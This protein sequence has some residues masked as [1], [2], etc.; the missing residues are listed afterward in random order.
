MV[1]GISGRLGRRLARKL[2]RRYKVIGVD[3]RPFPRKPKDIRHVRIDIRRRA[4]E[5]VFR[6]EDILAVIHL[7]ILHD[8]REDSREHHSINVQGTTQILEYCQRYSISKAIL[9]S[10][11]D[12]YGPRPENPQFLREEA[13]LMA[14]SGFPEVAHLIAVDL[15]FQSFFWKAPEVETVILRPVH[16]GGRVDN[17]MSRFLRMSLVP[18][19]AGFD[20]MIQLIHED[21]VI[22]GLLAALE[23]GVRGVFNLAG[24]CCVPLSRILQALGAK[25][26]PVPYSL[27]CW[28]LGKLWKWGLSSYPP[29][30]ADH[31]RFPCMVDDRRAREVLGFLPRYSVRETLKHLASATL[32]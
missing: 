24:P 4:A 2:H 5:T 20:P 31:L 10:S 29:A 6:S 30:E 27:G 18:T 7:A 8:P 12:L 14:S 23:P 25:S 32:Q 19:L 11:A 26:F 1:T 22:E 9:L 13:P 17:A 3:R 16:I 15:L 21:D 28:A